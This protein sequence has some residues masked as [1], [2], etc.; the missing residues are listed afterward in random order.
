MT[1]MNPK[2]W[3]CFA[4]SAAFLR[5]I[6]TVA[7]PVAKMSYDIDNVGVRLISLE[8]GRNSDVIMISGGL[9]VLRPNTP[10]HHE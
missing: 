2:C 4:I 3:M 9:I 6:V 7:A 5:V 1:F 8:Q 10:I